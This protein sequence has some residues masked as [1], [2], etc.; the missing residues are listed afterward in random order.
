MAMYLLKTLSANGL[1]VL[2]PTPLAAIVATQP[3]SLHHCTPKAPGI[4]KL[5]SLVLCKLL[6]QVK[7][8]LDVPHSLLH[9]QGLQVQLLVKVHEDLA[10]VGGLLLVPLAIHHDH[11]KV[12]QSL[13][14]VE[15]HVAVI[16]LGALP[17]LIGQPKAE[18][19]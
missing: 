19:H 3:T 18:G 2:E 15:H 14:H 8:G 7:L 12:M 6:E 5:Q 13:D 16:R 10:L 17:H 9:A 11:V 1:W 4:T